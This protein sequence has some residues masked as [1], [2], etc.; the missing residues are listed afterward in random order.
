MFEEMGQPRLARRLVGGANLVPDHVRHHRRAVIGNDDDL[1]TVRQREVGDLRTDPG[2][3]GS[4]ER[5]GKGGEGE[6]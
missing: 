5:R 6:R 2:M 4:G 3:G 1:E